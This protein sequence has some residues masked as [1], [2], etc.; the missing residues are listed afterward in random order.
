MPEVTKLTF[1]QTESP[2]KLEVALGGTKSGAMV[3]DA[4]VEVVMPGEDVEVSFAN[5]TST[6]T[7]FGVGTAFGAPV[8]DRLLEEELA[9]EKLNVEEFGLVKVVKEE[10]P[11]EELSPVEAAIADPPTPLHTKSPTAAWAVEAAAGTIG[12]R[13]AAGREICANR[14]GAHQL[15]PRPRPKRT[16]ALRVRKPCQ[17]RER[18][19]EWR[20][21]LQRR[22]AVR[23]LGGNG[24]QEIGRI[25]FGGRREKHF[26]ASESFMRIVY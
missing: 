12:R 11:T 26:Q 2:E 25:H 14:W 6:V 16:T 9:D 19:K 22:E 23:V 7:I 13:L 17:A 24:A 8:D 15:L 21:V 20:T 4:A 1:A 3:P 5:I 10:L 18:T